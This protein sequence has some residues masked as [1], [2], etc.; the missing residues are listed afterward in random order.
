M[1]IALH[2]LL[3]S[4]TVGINPTEV[5]LISITTPDQDIIQGELSLQQIRIRTASVLRV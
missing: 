4:E 3:D 1:D 2:A 5:P